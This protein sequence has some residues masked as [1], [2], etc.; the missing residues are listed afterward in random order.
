MLTVSHLTAAFGEF[1]VEDVSLAVEEGALFALVGASGAG[2][3]ALIELLAGLRLPDAGTI[4]VDGRDITRDRIQRRPFGLVY[5]DCTLF[6]HMS[7]RRNIA[8]GLRAGRLGR[9]AIRERTD[10]LAAQVGAYELLDR[11]PGTLSGG[12]AQRVAL[13]R[14]L[15]PEPRCLLLDEPLSSLDTRARAE[16]RA[17]LR[18]LNREGQ[19]MIHVTHDYAEAVSL[20]SHVAIIEAGRVIQT[21]PTAEVLGR[22]RSEF[23]ARFVGH[24][25]VIAGELRRP[26]DRDLPIVATL[27]PTFEVLTDAIAGPGHLTF[28][29]EDVQVSTHPPGASLGNVFRGTISEL[30]PAP[31]GLEVLVDIGVPIVAI[32]TAGSARALGLAPGR[33]V[34]VGIKAS[35]PTWIAA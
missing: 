19:T 23:V 16:L 28:R 32:V 35:S 33:E 10:H 9:R 34:F 15:G 20:A 6:P 29:A 25:N 26:A 17:L 18:R 24:G 5:Q 1:L 4:V 27:G 2:K 11:R 12:E 21:G 31:L 22:P 30:V 7:V 14:A 13:A 3:T 8:Y